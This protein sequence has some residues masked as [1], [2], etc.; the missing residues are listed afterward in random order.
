MKMAFLLFFLGCSSKPVLYPNQHYKEVGQ[1]QAL[2][3]IDEC[4][5]MGEQHVE[6]KTGKK[7]AQGLGAG[8]LI[9]GAMGAAT[10]IFTRSIASS[11]VRGATVGGAAGGAIGGVSSAG[12]DPVFKNFVDTCLREKGH[13]PMGWN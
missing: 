10:G 13:K 4:M 11:A 6:K 5:A 9:G 3:D 12:T 1:E 8:A 7:V 2:K